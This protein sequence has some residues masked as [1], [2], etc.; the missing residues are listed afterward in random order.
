MK[1]SA[2]IAAVVVAAAIAG[3]GGDD[4]SAPLPTSSDLTVEERAEQQF[5]DYFNALAGV[6]VWDD[7][8]VNAIANEASQ[9]FDTSKPEAERQAA[10][11]ALAVHVAESLEARRDEILNVKP[12][13][14]QT[15]QGLHLD[16]GAAADD[17]VTVAWNVADTLADQPVSTDS[18]Y[19]ALVE[20]LGGQAAAERLRDACSALQQQAELLALE[21]DLHCVVEYRRGLIE[22]E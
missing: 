2:L 13:P 1:T 14:P 5:E 3:C 16:L 7:A 21:V 9:A 17:L 20:E 10:I 4:D 19:G 12:Q 8:E 15:L 11:T 6:L 22:P 18:D